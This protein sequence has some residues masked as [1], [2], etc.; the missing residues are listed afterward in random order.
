[1][2]LSIT[3]GT[4]TEKRE[5]GHSSVERYKRGKWDGMMRP[6]Q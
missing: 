3:L 1:M 4:R 5:K 6:S 2:K